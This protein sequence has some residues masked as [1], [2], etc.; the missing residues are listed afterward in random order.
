MEKRF[1]CE[2]CNEKISKTLY[3]QHSTTSTNILPAQTAV[4]QLYY[5]S[6]ANSWTCDQDTTYTGLSK[7]LASRTSRTSRTSCEENE[8]A[9]MNIAGMNIKNMHYRNCLVQ[10]HVLF[11]ITTSSMSGD[12]D[13]EVDADVSISSWCI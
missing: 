4:I 6:A 9:S 1:H 2:H 11:N 13:F 10:Y 5:S 7:N 3:Y 12:D 8:S